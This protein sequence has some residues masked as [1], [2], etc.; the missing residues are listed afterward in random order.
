M[1]TPALG[2]CGTTG[3]DLGRTKSQETVNHLHL[4]HTVER[5]GVAPPSHLGH[6]YI[7][8]PTFN[9]KGR[10]GNCLMFPTLPMGI[11]NV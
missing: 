11:I 2:K 4:F 8:Y 5:I 10:G 3:R 9:K 7:L 6:H 1:A